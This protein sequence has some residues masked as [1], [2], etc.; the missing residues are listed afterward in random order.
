MHVSVIDSSFICG[1]LLLELTAVLHHDGLRGAPVLCSAL[2][3][4]LDH[5]VALQ[6]MTKHHMLAVEPRA[7]RHG[8]E[9]LR[10][11]RVRTRVRHRQLTGL[12]VLHL[13]VFVGEFLAVDGLTTVALRGL[14][15]PGGSERPIDQ[16]STNETQSSLPRA[17]PC[18]PPAS[19]VRCRR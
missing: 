4:L 19:D 12:G 18:R 7:R 8:D 14:H 9:E 6:H 10:A 11:V 13:E 16:R 17:T 3:H 15:F 2:L 1:S 5:G